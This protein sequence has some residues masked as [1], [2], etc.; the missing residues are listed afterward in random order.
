MVVTRSYQGIN[1]GNYDA[2]DSIQIPAG[3][4]LEDFQNPT[5]VRRPFNQD[6]AWRC[7]SRGSSTIIGPKPYR[8]AAGGRCLDLIGTWMRR[9][10]KDFWKDVFFLGH[11]C[12]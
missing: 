9:K 7:S 3:V 1:D 11:V 10:H 4:G 2:L 6:E 8:W 12:I 5:S